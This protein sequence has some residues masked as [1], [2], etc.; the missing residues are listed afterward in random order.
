M[1]PLAAASATHVAVLD[2]R[3]RPLLRTGYETTVP[4]R[5][6]WGADGERV[7]K[8]VGGRKTWFHYETAD[9]AATHGLRLSAEAAD[10]GAIVT[11]YLYIDGRMVARIDTPEA[12]D[13]LAGAWAGVK[14]V[15]LG[16]FGAHAAASQHA[17][18]VHVDQRGAVVAL[19]DGAAGLAWRA[20]YD[21]YGE[22]AIA[23]AK[24]TMNVRLAGQYFDPETRTHDNLQREY[25]PSTGRYLAADPISTNPW[26]DLDQTS[27]LAGV[28]A[29]AYASNDPLGHTDSQGLYESDVHYYM[30]YFLAIVA[31][32]S[33]D[34]ARMMAL[35]TQFVDDDTTTA[36]VPPGAGTLDTI[37]SI[38]HNT[39]QLKK[40]HFALSDPVTGRTLKAFADNTLDINIDDSPQLSALHSY[41][42]PLFMG[43]VYPAEQ[44][45]VAVHGGISPYLRR[46][47]RPSRHRQ[48][49]LQRGHQCPGCLATGHGTWNRRKKSRLHLQPY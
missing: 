7:A 10:D 45:V 32:M 14:R 39:D 38:F 47:I 25:Q 37:L 30:T 28:N 26:L 19:S 29:F 24:I 35:A 27:R 46:Y 41:A 20:R 49:S 34:D 36:P 48:Y 5:Y 22:A 6:Q 33:P 3:S 44:S 23:V 15:V 1:Q 8:I 18:A 31:G 42:V 43:G 40:Y 4:V 21:A 16:W 11:R 13:G 12:L 2:S 9:D 17:Y